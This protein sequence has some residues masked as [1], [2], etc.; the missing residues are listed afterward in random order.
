MHIFDEKIITILGVDRSDTIKG[1]VQKLEIFKKFLELFPE[2]REKV[3][4]LQILIP[5]R[6]DVLKVR[7]LDTEINLKV[8][9]INS[10]YGNKDYT[11]LILIKKSVS[12][13]QLSNL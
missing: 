1:I 10:L 11:P 13:E 8:S 7:E 9:E 2:F 12:F 6:N 3:Q 4:L 5:S